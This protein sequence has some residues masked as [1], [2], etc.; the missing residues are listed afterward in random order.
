VAGPL[1]I[2]ASADIGGLGARNG[3]AVEH[4]WERASPL[5][6]LVPWLMVGVLLL[7]RPNRSPQA[8]WV[9][10][11]L[12]LVTA[13]LAVLRGLLA[14]VLPSEAAETFSEILSALSFGLAA[15]WLLSPYMGRKS[16][17]VAFVA[18]GLTLAGA[19]AVTAAVRADWT[20]EA[21]EQFVLMMA[22]VVLGGLVA[23]AMSLASLT[24]RRDYRPWRFSW[25]LIGWLAVLP[26]LLAVVGMV[27]DGGPPPWGKLAL[28]VV[29]TALVLFLTA[30]P[31]LALSFT[32]PF[33]RERLQALLRA[34]VVTDT[35]APAPAPT[36][37]V[38]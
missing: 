17:L 32:Q 9:A 33:Y 34:P 19:G 27:L 6:A 29:G 24:C 35:L 21:S 20:R 2:V 36:P 30:L 1:Q 37:I 23:L 11:P 12:V 13:V 7:L 31:F 5:P 3:A 14:P 16:R 22:P 26:S 8:W 10:L 25:R 38:S 4:V 15:L 18:M 28:F